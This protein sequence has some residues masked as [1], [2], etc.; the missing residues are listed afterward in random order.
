[1]D[2][3]PK[4]VGRGSDQMGRMT[5]HGLCE[6]KLLTNNFFDHIR[7]PKLS[8]GVWQITQVLKTFFAWL[9][10]FYIYGTFA[11]HQ[12]IGI[13]IIIMS[14]SSNPTTHHNLATLTV[15]SRL[16][17]HE[18]THQLQKFI[19]MICIYWFQNWS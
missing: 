6:L 5:Q 14:N 9:P 13:Q 16:D 4:W 7:H 1:M 8:G 11:I 12:Y 19:L 3:L 2:H 18:T 17:L 15:K 10:L